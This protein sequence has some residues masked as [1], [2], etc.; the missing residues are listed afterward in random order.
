MIIHLKRG[1]KI[2]D[3]LDKLRIMSEILRTISK[4]NLNILQT[5]EMF[6]FT[7]EKWKL[8]T[9]VNLKE[10][11]KTTPICLD[12]VYELSE[13]K[14]DIEILENRNH[15]LHLKLNQ[16]KNTNKIL[17]YAMSVIFIISLLT[18]LK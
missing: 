10:L 9:K 7:L 18:I 17:I 13:M 4:Y 6:N 3:P 2:I 14:K 15:V 12:E 5:E 11:Q 8:N 1:P 16:T